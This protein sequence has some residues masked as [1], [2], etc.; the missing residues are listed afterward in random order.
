MTATIAQNQTL[1]T[2]L[3]F[4]GMGIPVL[5]LTPGDK[6]PYEKL[7]PHGFNDATTDPDTIESWFTNNPEAG[8]GAKSVVLTDGRQFVVLDADELQGEGSGL[9]DVGLGVAHHFQDHAGRCADAAQESDQAAVDVVDA[10]ADAA[11]GFGIVGR[12][13]DLE[14]EGQVGLAAADEVGS[15]VDHPARRLSCAGVDRQQD[16]EEFGRLLRGHGL[17]RRQRRGPS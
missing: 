13:L 9:D 15:V 10:Q 12:Q 17:A 4:A 8:L 1:T 3:G 16:Q 7:A 6:A 5:P 11:Q 14:R 2:A